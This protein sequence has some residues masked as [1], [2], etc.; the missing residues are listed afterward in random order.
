MRGRLLRAVWRRIAAPLMRCEMRRCAGAIGVWVCLG[1]VTGI[2]VQLNEG[3]LTQYTMKASRSWYA[4][5]LISPAGYLG[6]SIWGCA[7]QP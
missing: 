4:A 1:S 6:S 5:H 7:T 3:G 2:E